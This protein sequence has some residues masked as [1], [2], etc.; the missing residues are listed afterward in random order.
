MSSVVP[1]SQASPAGASQRRLQV[2]LARSRE[3]A[4][5]RTVLEETVARVASDE[6]GLQADL[7]ALQLECAEL[8]ERLEQ[9]RRRL[10]SIDEELVNRQDLARA[11]RHELGHARQ[12]LQRI[13]R[14]TRNL[15]R[16]LESRRIAL[17]SARGVFAD[18]VETVRRMQHKLQHANGDAD[19][20]IDWE[21]A[22]GGLREREDR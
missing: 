20:G 5:E 21:L 4:G 17:S 2:A 16:E 10:A 9:S 13:S 7:A 1:S 3:L 18:A 8:E 14:A 19:L 12:Q 11:E 15:E 6:R 22:R